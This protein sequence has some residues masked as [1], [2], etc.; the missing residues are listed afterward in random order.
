M[1]LLTGKQY[2]QRNRERATKW[3]NS[4]KDK[5]YKNFNMMLSP[6]VQD[7]ISHV[8]EGTKLSNAE[9][10]ELIIKEYRKLKSML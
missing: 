4:L 7:A 8:K 6:K 2:R 3:R 1:A 9:A 5:G 10:I